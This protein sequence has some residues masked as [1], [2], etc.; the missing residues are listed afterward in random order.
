MY[1]RGKC[2]KTNVGK[3]AYG[4]GCGCCVSCKV[5]QQCSN[6]GGICLKKC[7]K[8]KIIANAVCSTSGNNGKVKCKCCRK[9]KKT[10]TPTTTTPLSSTSAITISQST[11]T[12]VSGIS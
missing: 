4:S 1:S 6:A 10:P 2:K 11:K 9:D 3:W 8:K 5:T 12:T 7:N